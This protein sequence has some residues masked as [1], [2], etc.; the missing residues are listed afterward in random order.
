MQGTAKA[1]VEE[2]PSMVN[3]PEGLLGS[4]EI[5]AWLF[6]EHLKQSTNALQQK[7]HSVATPQAP[8]RNMTTTCGH[9]GSAACPA[10]PA[11]LRC[12]SF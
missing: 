11:A 12:L 10:T 3:S 6:H 2:L 9:K 7:Q 1:G 4:Q 5:K 8:Y